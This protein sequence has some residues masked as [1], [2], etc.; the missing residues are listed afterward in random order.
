[1]FDNQRALQLM[2]DNPDVVRPYI[3][4]L[5]TYLQNH[6]VTALAY[7]IYSRDELLPKAKRVIDGDSESEIIDMPNGE[8]REINT[9]LAQRAY[10]D[11]LLAM[12]TSLLMIIG[13]GDDMPQNNPIQP[14]VYERFREIAEPEQQEPETPYRPYT[15]S[16]EQEPAE[17]QEPE[18]AQGPV[19]EEQEPAE[20]QEVGAP[21]RSR[22]VRSRPV[23]SQTQTQEDESE[24]VQDDDNEWK[25]EVLNKTGVEAF[26]EVVGMTVEE[27]EARIDEL[28]NEGYTFRTS[29]TSIENT[30]L[31]SFSKII[32]MIGGI[33]RLY[34]K[35]EPI[36]DRRLFKSAI[37]LNML[38]YK[39]VSGDENISEE[40]YE[41]IR[42][43]E[44]LRSFGLSLLIVKAII[45]S[46]KGYN[47]S[48]NK[49]W[50][51][52]FKPIMD[53]YLGNVGEAI[54][55]KMVEVAE[56]LFNKGLEEDRIDIFKVSDML[57]EKN[58]EK[59]DSIMIKKE[60]ELLDVRLG[61]TNISYD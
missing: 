50:N 24:E 2:Q 27:L 35:G 53:K 9:D 43:N 46:N 6:N 7:F 25:E 60:Q 34:S 47:K 22:P 20:E 48:T 14:A 11:G 51:R 49:V 15:P 58:F 33:K 57:K 29:R 32:N 18:T 8:Q 19:D 4:A 31:E 36:T 16:E 3:E 5:P 44:V 10:D 21:E 30:D 28:Y 61:N 26:I 39:F 1:M 13:S 56:S 41:G 45:F 17:E 23:R 59:V 37:L 42:R 54:I 38:T 52:D 12:L 55:N 40:V